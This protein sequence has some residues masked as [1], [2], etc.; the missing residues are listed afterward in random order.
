MAKNSFK[1]PPSGFNL[2][3]IIYVLFKHKW[4]VALLAV[5]GAGGAV[6]YFLKAAVL[7]E[8]EAMLMVR[9]IVERS[10]V[11]NINSTTG[12]NTGRDYSSIMQAEMAILNSWDLAESVA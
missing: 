3:D 8:S 6:A 11:D 2:G 5:L 1:P 9:Y 12:T 4:K 7:Y 10:P